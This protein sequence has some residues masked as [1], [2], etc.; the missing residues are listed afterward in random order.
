MSKRETPDA[1][2][3]LDAWNENRGKLPAALGMPGTRRTHAHKRLGE[4]P[5]LGRWARGVVRLARSSFANGE[6]DRQW[7]ATID[8]L[9]RPDTLTKIEEGK[10]DDRVTIPKSAS[11]ETICEDVELAASIEAR[12]MKAHLAQLR[13]LAKDS[14]PEV[15]HEANKRLREL[16]P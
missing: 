2:L 12:D 14:D 11:P 9:L 8:F 15:A 1:G 10:Y 16:V 4:V 3:M 13:R 5:D 6:N 7:V